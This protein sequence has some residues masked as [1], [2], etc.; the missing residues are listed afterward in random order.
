MI[1][2]LYEGKPCYANVYEFDVP[3]E[4]RVH[5]VNSVVHTNL[6]ESLVLIK[7]N[8]KLCLPEKDHIPTDLVA[9]IVESIEEHMAR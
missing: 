1:R 2:F 6:P 3:K 5:I 4:F 8:E 9:A 7:Q